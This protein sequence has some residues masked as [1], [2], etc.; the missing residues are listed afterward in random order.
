[1][2]EEHG[3]SRSGAEKYPTWCLEDDSFPFKTVPFQ[4]TFVDS[5]INSEKQ[6]LCK[7][8]CPSM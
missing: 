6:A 8:R 7:L 1:M 4:G 2:T 5:L 3:F